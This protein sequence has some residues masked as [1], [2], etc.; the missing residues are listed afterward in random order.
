MAAT[1][2]L[3]AATSAAA[4]TPTELFFSEYIEGSSFNKAIEIFNG[5]G[6]T[7][8][9]SRYTVQ[10]YSN[11]AATPSQTMSLSGNLADS[12]VHVLAHGSAGPEIK[13]VADGTN[14]SVINWTGD[15]AVALVKNGAFVDVIGQIGVDP[16]SQWGTGD[17]STAENTLR[18]TET[19][20]A[21]DTNGSDA[22]DPA[23]EWDGFAQDTFDGL[24]S[25]GAPPA[26]DPPAVEGVEPRNNNSGVAT[27]ESVVVTF[28]EAVSATDAFALV[29]DD[30]PVTFDVTDGGDTWTL[31]P[32]QA[33]PAGATCTL[34]VE[35]EK[36]VDEDGTADP[37]AA[38]FTSRFFTAD[39]SAAYTPAYE[40]QGSGAS[41]PLRGVHS[42]KGVVVGD[43][44]TATGLGGFYLRDLEGDGDPATSDA[45]FIFNDYQDEV[46]LGDVVLARGFVSE[47]FGQTQLS[48]FGDAVEICGNGASVEPTPVAMPFDGEADK[49][50]YE[51]MLVALP[52]ALTVTETYFL[53]RFGEVALSSDGRL[54][55]P[56]NVVEPGVEANE[57]QAWNDRNMILLDDGTNAENPDPILFG[58]GGEE[59]TA[60]N[61]LRSGDLAR[62]VVGVMTYTWGGSSSSPNAF[63]VHPVGALGGSYDFEAVNERP[64]APDEVGGDLRVASFNVLNYFNTFRG[65]TGGVGGQSMDCRGADNQAELDRQADKI[66]AALEGLDADVVGL[67]E[68]ENDGYGP[69]S[70]IADLTQRLN[71][72]APEE[73]VYEYVDADAETG[74][75]NVLGTDAIKVGLLYKPAAVEMVGQTAV[76]NS[77]EFETGGDSEPRNRPALAQ[78]FEDTDGGRFTVVV[79]HLKS[80]GSACEAPDT[81]AGQANC[82]EVRVRA[83]QLLAEWLA[84][85][86][87]ASGDTDVLIVGDLNSYAKEDPIDVL[88]EAGYKDLVR[89]Y[90]GKDAYS[91]VFDGQWGY[92]DHAL[93][94]PHLARQVT[95]ATTWHINADEPS[96]LDYDTS[97]KSARADEV[98]YAPDA[99]RSSDHDPV[100]VGL[101]LAPSKPGADVETGKKGNKARR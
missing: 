51:G 45:V 64:A 7:V 9:L 38:D 95:G 70:A 33:L 93:A 23:A 44:E 3:T 72:G 96:A 89:R 30:A 40:I 81:G 67:I 24:G 98:L 31:D 80:K 47:R 26:D 21:G 4:T 75:A 18:R 39:C 13:A 74:G 15:D 19:V 69:D 78:A 82:N 66:V 29:C 20:T 55:Q 46:E 68:I 77:E 43:Y 8:D 22:F 61:T 41:T 34:M 32:Q 28:T 94:S 60:K 48:A 100:L 16:G 14:S 62:D 101:D 86:P 10:L 11:G 12:D 84:T 88:K 52:D 97:Y 42:T 6:Q 73:D 71:A 59:L 36:V 35:A 50:R 83:A 27:T 54:P 76:L 2:P 1:L 99:Y 91:Y 49:E 53:G 57:L 5:T 65:C 25:H 17:T 58:R 87:T 37:M 63:R 85:D 56:T 90:E 79:N 92:L